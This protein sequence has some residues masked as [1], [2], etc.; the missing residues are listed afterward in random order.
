MLAPHSGISEKVMRFLNASMTKVT[1]DSQGRVVLPA[2]LVA[3]AQI[4]K[5]AVV[6][7]CGKYAEIWSESVY[8]QMKSEI[9][10]EGLIEELEALGL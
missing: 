3:H 7:G 6:V 9:D 8:D 10:M 2:E 4:E 1:P 5:D